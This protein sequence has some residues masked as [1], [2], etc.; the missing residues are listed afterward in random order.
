MTISQQ[1][2]EIEKKYFQFTKNGNV[3]VSNIMCIT[4]I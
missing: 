4:E 2:Y 1:I 3:Y